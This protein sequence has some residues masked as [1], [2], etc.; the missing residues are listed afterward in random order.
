MP[1][2]DDALSMMARD[3]PRIDHKY[4]PARP[5]AVTSGSL[6]SPAPAP[7]ERRHWS[8]TRSDRPGGGSGQR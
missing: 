8:S 3:F 4:S 6:S 5:L 7:I 2:A 1:V